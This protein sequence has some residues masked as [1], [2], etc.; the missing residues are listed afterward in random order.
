M[1]REGFSPKRLDQDWA[2]ISKTFMPPTKLDGL[3]KI[4]QISKRSRNE[5][6]AKF[7]GNTCLHIMKVI[8]GTT[9]PIQTWSL[10]SFSWSLNYFPIPTSV[11]RKNS[12]VWWETF[13]GGRR[14]MALCHALKQLAQTEE[15]PKAHFLFS[16]LLTL[17]SN[18]RP[19]DTLKQED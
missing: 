13:C 1:R 5:K 11:P 7:W 10:S 12:C 16:R 17:V 6:S 19:K 15:L 18:T 2:A 3:K 4:I 14:F 9:Q 8:V